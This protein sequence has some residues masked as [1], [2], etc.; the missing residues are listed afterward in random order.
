M[1]LAPRRS[2][3][4]NRNVL[5][6]TDHQIIGAPRQHRLSVGT[7]AH[8]HPLVVHKQRSPAHTTQYISLQS[9]A[10]AFLFSCWASIDALT[11]RA[12][13]CGIPVSRRTPEGET[14]NNRWL[15]QQQP[16]APAAAAADPPEA[17]DHS[18][19]TRNL[20]R[21]SGRPTTLNPFYAVHLSLSALLSLALL[22]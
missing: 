4:G 7:H 8:K 20:G 1:P 11:C 15:R 13:K 19:K 5:P 17:L 16:L 18:K 12:L 9:G 22:S 14:P 6:Q 2:R 10:S 3:R 21:S